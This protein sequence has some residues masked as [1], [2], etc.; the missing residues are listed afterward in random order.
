MTKKTGKIG[1]RSG[2]VQQLIVFSKSHL[3]STVR[4]KITEFIN[5]FRYLR[6]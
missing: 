2:L 5:D 3:N 6:N 4:S 1:P